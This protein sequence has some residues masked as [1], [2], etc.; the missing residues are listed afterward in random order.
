MFEQ[1]IQSQCRRNTAFHILAQS[2][3]VDREQAAFDP[4]KEEGDDPAAKNGKRS[5][6]CFVASSADASSFSLVA[7]VFSNNTSSMRFR[8]ARRTVMASRWISS[9][10]PDGGRSGEHTS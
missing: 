10:V 7:I 4:V 5:H 6:N 8:P 1:P 2:H 9:F 3:R